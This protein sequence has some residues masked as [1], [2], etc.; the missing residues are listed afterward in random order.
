MCGTRAT[1][2]LVGGRR[3]FPQ[4]GEKSAGQRSF[5]ANPTDTGSRYSDFGLPGSDMEM[6]N[7]DLE[8]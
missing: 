4:S 8:D 1:L 3:Q 6:Q 5:P 7:T 2:V